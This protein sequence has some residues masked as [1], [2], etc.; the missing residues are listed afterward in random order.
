[1]RR[2]FFVAIGIA[3]VVIAQLS[4]WDVGVHAWRLGRGARTIFAGSP[5]ADLPLRTTVRL[6]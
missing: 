6:G 2:R 5:S 3:I 1:M 4:Y